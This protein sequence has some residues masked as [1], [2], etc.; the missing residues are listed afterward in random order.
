MKFYG[1]E[2]SWTVICTDANGLVM[3]HHTG[4]S[5]DRHTTWDMVSKKYGSR[6]EPIDG[7]YALVL[8]PGTH[9]AYAY[10]NIG[11]DTISELYK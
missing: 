4:G 2:M 1:E 5:H 8:I 11:D 6:A 9:L 10:K 7:Y 3:I